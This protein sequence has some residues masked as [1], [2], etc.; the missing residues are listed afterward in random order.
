MIIIKGKT[1]QHLFTAG[2][3]PQGSI[4][5]KD[6]NSLASAY[7]VNFHSAPVWIG[8]LP[9]DATHVG[10]FE[11]IAYAWIDSLIINGNKLYG[12]FSDVSPEL[13]YLIE[14]GKFKFVSV[15]LGYYNIAGKNNLYLHAVALTNRPAVD[16]MEPLNLPD[17]FT[18]SQNSSQHNFNKDCQSKLFYNIKFIHMNENLL[19]IAKSLG[20]DT[21]NIS[22]D[23]ALTE[24]I[25]A[26][27]AE[28]KN[29]EAGEPDAG[30]EASKHAK[31]NE[32]L[33][34]KI[35]SLENML[36]AKLVDDGISAGKVLPNQRESLIAF[37]K[38][39]YDAC[40]KLIDDAPVNPL[41]SQSK[42]I[43]DVPAVQKKIDLK[44]AK[45]S[46][47]GK[48]LTYDEVISDVKLFSKFTDDELLALKE[49]SK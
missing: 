47:D 46:K 14:S 22:D 25:N 24:A 42:Q 32:T 21:A 9:P 23:A 7:N 26:K 11:P 6:L 2:K 30:M 20:L 4:S 31:K 16:S 48:E 19:A 43:Q 45:F 27:I 13:K 34:T 41:L 44:D 37:A 38:Q 39:N 5:I 40:K 33:E 3:Y 29:D 36:F 35:A 12:S 28:L 8:H 1:Y 17:D 18:K 49:K 10:G 15:E